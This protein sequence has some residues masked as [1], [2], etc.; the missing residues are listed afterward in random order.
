MEISKKSGF[1]QHQRLWIS[2]SFLIVLTFVCF[3]VPFFLSYHY[4]EQNI[5][6]GATAPSWG[7]WF[8]TDM[9]G[10]DLCARV[11]YGGRISLSIGAVA[12]LTAL[13]IGTLYGSVSGYVGGNVDMLMMRF[14][15]ILYPLPLTLFVI[16]LMTIVGR[17][18]LALFL[19][20]GAIEWLTPA[21]IVRAEVNLLRDRGFVQSSRLLGQSTWNIL[22][23][24]IYPNLVD[25]LL[26][27]GT[28]TLP[29]IMLLESFLSFLGLGVQAPQSSWGVLIADGVQFIGIYPWLLLIPSLFFVITLLALNFLG[30]GLRDYYLRQR[31]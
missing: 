1:W 8:G 10:R 30:D 17:N 23:L 2:V 7:H 21:R 16:L 26:V 29:N 13:L 11:L 27:Y 9:L 5:S 22:R 15:D 14:V 19:A 3:V 6:L 25:T 12:T 24:H 18:I 28:L 20:I 4:D 31:S